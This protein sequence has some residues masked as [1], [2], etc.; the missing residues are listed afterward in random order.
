MLQQRGQRIGSSGSRRRR[1]VHGSRAEDI[2]PGERLL[3]QCRRLHQPQCGMLFQGQKLENSL[4][5][6]LLGI[7]DDAAALLDDAALFPGDFL[8]GVAQDLRVLQTDAHDQRAVRH[9]DG[10]GGIETAA[11][12]HLQ[13]HDIAVLCL[14]ILEGQRRQNFEF[15]GLV[16]HG[17]NMRPEKCQLSGQLRIGNLLSIDGPALI[18]AEE[19]GEM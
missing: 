16:R 4:R 10:I 1:R 12:T 6:G 13:H 11:E 18:H 15:G 7:E 19:M 17:Q 2:I 5:A 9:R 3:R 14:E 8:D